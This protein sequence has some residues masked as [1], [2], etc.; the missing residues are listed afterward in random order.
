VRQNLRFAPPPNTRAPARARPVV[1]VLAVVAAA[2]LSIGVTVTL[3]G[4]HPSV[5]RCAPGAALHTLTLHPQTLTGESNLLHAALDTIGDIQSD[6][7][8]ADTTDE[9]SAVAYLQS[10]LQAASAPIS[11]KCISAK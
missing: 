10:Y 9:D 8:A 11:M 3:T 7:V 6:R 4:A 5:A 1:A 2:A